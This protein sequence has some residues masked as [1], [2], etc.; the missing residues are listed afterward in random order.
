MDR[1]EREG[2][3]QANLENIQRVQLVAGR[4]DRTRI[5]HEATILERA[6]LTE[7]EICSHQATEQG[8]AALERLLRLAEEGQSRHA[9]DVV[10]FLSTVRDNGALPL[11][12]LRGLEQ[13]VA[14]D[15]LAVIDAYRHARLDLVAHVHGGARR[16]ARA[17]HPPRQSA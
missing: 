15:M 13:P 4:G 17:V 8:L 1:V 12:L 9:R 5:D 11:R 10:A 3:H 14:D 16:L 2:Q 6:R 7:E